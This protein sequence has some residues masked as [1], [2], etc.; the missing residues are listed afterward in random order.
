MDDVLN[1]VLS[2]QRIV[3][4][5]G[6]STLTYEQGTMNLKLIDRLAMVL[7]D[8]RNQG[9]EIIL[10]SSGAIG[11]A[12]GKLGLDKKPED[13]KGK[14][15]AAAVGQCE[16][17]YLYDKMFGEYNNI[18]AQVLL[19]RDDIAI[20]RRKRN[21]QNTV[22]TLLEMGIIPI[23]NENDTVS[24]DEIEIGDNDTLSAVVA[25]LVN[26][27]LLVLFSDIDGLYDD[28]PHKNKNAKFLPVVY[29]IDEVKNAAG[30]AGTSRGTGG[31][32]TK[33][34]A[35]ER[36]TNAGIHMIIA[37]GNNVDALYDILAGQNVGTLFVSKNFERTE[38]L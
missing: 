28:D 25:E 11:I 24:F 5:V 32:V 3:V 38:D 10:V 13:T 6:T 21:I 22:T 18:V 29:N 27:D 8:L 26:A 35:A 37:N 4:K 33:L 31:M 7:S 17:M 36:A 12:L 2:A 19:T 16:L 1:D 9:K 34:E 30:G 23:V 15:A 20:P 14:Q